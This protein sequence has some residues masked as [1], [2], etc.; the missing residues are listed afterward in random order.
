M[1]GRFWR[2]RPFGKKS[3]AIEARAVAHRDADHVFAVN[4]GR[5]VL[6]DRAGLGLGEG[7]GGRPNSCQ[8]ARERS[9][10]AASVIA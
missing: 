4:L 9:R 8:E 3:D 6:G 5:E 2:G 7:I 1:V 10:S